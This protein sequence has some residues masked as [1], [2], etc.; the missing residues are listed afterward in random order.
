MQAKANKAA[1]ARQAALDAQSVAEA[2]QRHAHEQA[3]EA[4]GQER[5]DVD[6]QKATTEAKAEAARELHQNYLDELAR[7]KAETQ[8]HKDAQ[9]FQLK[10][11]KLDN[12]LKLG[13]AK[14][15]G[16]K[17]VAEVHANASIAV[18]QIHASATVTAAQIRASHAGRSRG[19]A[20]TG[21]LSPDGQKF[22]QMLSSTN[23]PADPRAAKAALDQSS[24]SASD[25]GIIEGILASKGKGEY[26][27]P[28][29]RPATSRAASGLATTLR[30][31]IKAIQAQHPEITNDQL[32]QAAKQDGFTDETIN[33]V[34]P[35]GK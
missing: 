2:M 12:D 25:K 20:D 13:L 17:D 10:K 32:R 35:G 18:A 7:L 28:T 11:Q 8:E 3:M 22:L 5:I 4:Q 21:G 23:N 29:Y 19:A 24:L 16:S 6:Q 30:S 34:L 27:T 26:V 15:H 33:S 31:K 1:Q 14:I 9:E